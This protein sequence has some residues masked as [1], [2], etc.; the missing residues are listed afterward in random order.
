MGA[1][2]YGG[3]WNKRGTPLLYCASTA[4]LCALEILAHSAGLP[5]GMVLIEIDIPDTFDVFTIF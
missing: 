3:R 5:I 1:E 2:L 4:S